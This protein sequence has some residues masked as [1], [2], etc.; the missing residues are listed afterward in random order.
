MKYNRYKPVGWINESVRH[1]LASRGIRT[2]SSIS[3][4]PPPMWHRKDSSAIHY[5]KI[6]SSTISRLQEFLHKKFTFAQHKNPD[7][8]G[9]PE[10]SKAQ[11]DIGKISNWQKFR[12][13]LVK[14]KNTVILMGM[15]GL[16]GIIGVTAGVPTLMQNV[17]TGEIIAV[18]GSIIGRTGMIVQTILTGQA[19]T[20]EV[21]VIS[22]DMNAQPLVSASEVDINSPEPPAYV[23]KVKPQMDK[24]SDSDYDSD[25]GDLAKMSSPPIPL[26]KLDTVEKRNLSIAM[27]KV[28]H[29][30][31]ERGKDVDFNDKNFQIVKRVG[32]DDTAWGAHQGQLIQIDRDILKNQDKLEGVLTHEVV[33]RVYDIRDETRDL[34]NIQ[35]DIIGELL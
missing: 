5:A 30:F 16:A 18:G 25:Y 21:K 34:E 14:H 3:L 17:N 11:M 10:V 33:H 29:L 9:H 13:W 27:K 26:D 28:K 35:M 22:H 4:N 6:D 12:E 1:S 2:K 32:N 23:I 7:L 20:E 31:K 15:G 24:A 19:V 8:I